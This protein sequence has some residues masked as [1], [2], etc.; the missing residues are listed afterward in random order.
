MIEVE[1]R[2]EINEFNNIFRTKIHSE[3]ATTVAGYLLEKIKK[4]PK[5]GEIFVIENLQFKISGASPN[6]IEKILI[7]KIRKL[8]SEKKN[9]LK[10]KLFL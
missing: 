6:K 10:R 3:D 9:I 4:I 8:K 2:I 1:G 5:I 7:T